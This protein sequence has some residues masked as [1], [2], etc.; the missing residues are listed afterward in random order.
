MEAFLIVIPIKTLIR[1][2]AIKKFLFQLFNHIIWT[3]NPLP[4][5]FR[6]KQVMLE[7]SKLHQGHKTFNI[8]IW[9]SALTGSWSYFST[10]VNNSNRPTNVIML[11]FR[12]FDSYCTWLSPFHIAQKTF[13][14]HMTK[15]PVPPSFPQVSAIYLMVYNLTHNSPYDCIFIYSKKEKA[16]LLGPFLNYAQF[17][18]S[19]NLKKHHWF[20]Q[21]LI[22]YNIHDPL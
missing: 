3:T 6:E 17:H 18:P 12:T 11:M 5:L 4:L 21:F 16:A 22:T 9:P 19:H 8:I 14:L 13:L 1:L 15:P 7:S 20:R 10:L 2:W